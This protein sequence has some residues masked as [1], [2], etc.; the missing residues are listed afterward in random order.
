[1]GLLGEKRMAKD[2][3]LLILFILRLFG[4]KYFF[5]AQRNDIEFHPIHTFK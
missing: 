2:I 5:H 1:M 3:V 4:L